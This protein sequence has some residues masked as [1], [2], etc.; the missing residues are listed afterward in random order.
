MYS[1][2]KQG[3]T[4][5]TYVM[6]VVADYLKD[7]DTL[8][9]KKWGPGSTCFVIE[10]ASNWVLGSDFIWH[11]VLGGGTGGVSDEVLNEAIAKAVAESKMYTDTAIQDI[12]QFNVILVDTLPVENIQTN[13]IYFVPMSSSEENN[14]YFE[15]M[16]I[17]GAWEYIGSTQIEL[18]DYYT[19]KEVEEYIANNKYVLPQAS[20]TTLGGVKVD[21]TSII[22]NE[23]GIISVSSSYATEE[24]VNTIIENNIASVPNDAIENLF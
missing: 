16:F 2:R 8:P 4:V 17:N 20:D 3:D 10:D 9:S 1:I 14:G 15:Y 12:K 18:S 24:N 23:D 5:Q 6:E 13:A 19:K 21:N 11:P 22:I 7:I